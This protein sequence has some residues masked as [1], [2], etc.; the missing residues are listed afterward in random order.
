VKALLIM[1]HG[2]PRPEANDDIRK[3]ADVIR[4]R[5]VYPYVTIGYLDCNEPDIAAAIDECVAAGAT[6]IAAVPYFLHSG[7]HMLRDLPAIL[8]ERSV[9]YPK[10]RIVMGDYVGQEPQMADVLRDRVKAA[11]SG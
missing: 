9:C 6:D 3:L 4:E 8:A 10:V 7:K 11:S 5:R 2:S 1:T